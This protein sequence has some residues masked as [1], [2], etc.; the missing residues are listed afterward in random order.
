MT[1]SYEAKIVELETDLKQSL[2]YQSVEVEDYSARL[3][4]QQIEYEKI[5]K[6]L[7][8]EREALTRLESTNCK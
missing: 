4:T 8:Q 7:Y 5:Q 2:H 1:A 3:Q 6:V